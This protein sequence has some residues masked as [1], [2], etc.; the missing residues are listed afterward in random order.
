MS[1]GACDSVLSE[2]ERCMNLVEELVR[3]T[4]AVEVIEAIKSGKTVGSCE[5]KATFSEL[6][7]VARAQ[8]L[9]INFDTKTIYSKGGHVLGEWFDDEYN[10]ELRQILNIV[11]TNFGEN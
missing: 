7:S 8:G 1:R 9:T 3:Y 2:R 6:Y 5:P 4:D 10:N 11:Y